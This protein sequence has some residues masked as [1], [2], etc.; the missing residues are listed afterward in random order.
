MTNLKLKLIKLLIKSIYK[1]NKKTDSF[2]KYFE[3]ITD[4]IYSI[5]K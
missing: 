2:N 3:T 1:Y 5:L 4:D